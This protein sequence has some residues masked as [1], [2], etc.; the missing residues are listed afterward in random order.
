[1]FFPI[2]FNSMNLNGN[3]NI[4]GL[5][6]I[7]WL[8]ENHNNL[9][10]NPSTKLNYELLYFLS[11]KSI[12]Y[13]PKS[14]TVQIAQNQFRD[15]N[16]L[17]Q[18]NANSST[19]NANLIESN[20]AGTVS[21]AKNSKNICYICQNNTKLE[22]LLRCDF[23]PLSYHLD[24][25]NPPLCE[26][27]SKEKFWMCPNHVEHIL[28]HILPKSNR[29]TQRIKAYNAY[30]SIT[31]KDE[32]ENSK[33]HFFKKI[34]LLNKQEHFKTNEKNLST[35]TTSQLK[36]CEIPQAIKQIYK[37]RIKKCEKKTESEDEEQANV[38]TAIEALQ[39]L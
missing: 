28:E 22:K 24:C 37:K 7:E 25:L 17:N 12:N 6:K 27:P 35:P 33:F 14:F 26:A 11:Q 30:S 5:N 1:M 20:T 8:Y 15:I 36:R 31:T 39:I 3:V 38:S 16:S 10:A 2:E 18:A 19:N 29:L 9:G 23:C 21:L 13:S 32:I 4:P 34:N